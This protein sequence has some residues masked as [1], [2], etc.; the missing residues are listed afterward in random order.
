MGKVSDARP[1][2]F[3]WTAHLY[4]RPHILAASQRMVSVFG[5]PKALVFFVFFSG[6]II[7]PLVAWAAI[8]ARRAALYSVLVVGLA[9][10]FASS[11]GGFSP[12]QAVLLGLWLVTTI[13]FLVAFPLQHAKWIFPRDAFLYLWITGF[14]A[15]MFVVMGWVAARYYVIVVPAAVFAAVRLV[16]MKWPSA[17]PRIL[18]GMIAATFFLSGVLAYADYNQAGSARKLANDLRAAGIA[19]GERHFYLGDSFTVS[20]LRSEGWTP[21]FPETVFQPGDLVVAHEVT[22]PLIWFF[23]KHLELREVARFEYST[24]CPVKVMHFAGS[25]GFYASVWGALPFTFTPGP[26]ERYHLLEVVSVPAS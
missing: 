13:L 2:D 9:V 15:M 5:W 4:G 10:F 12:G 1:E 21:S 11:R 19:G 23:K 7:A 6:V 3:F 25:A 8:G 26:W 22:M 18:R 17:A 16:E 20:Y 24:K 14:F